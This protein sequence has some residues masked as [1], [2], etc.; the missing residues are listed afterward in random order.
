M[1]HGLARKGKQ[2]KAVMQLIEANQIPHEYLNLTANALNCKAKLGK[3]LGD[4][5]GIIFF[6]VKDNN[7]R[8]NRWLDKKFDNYRNHT[9]EHHYELDEKY[10]KVRMC[11]VM[12]LPPR[13]K[14]NSKLGGC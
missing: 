11:F 10:N 5:G 4:Q 2:T 8:L 14:K 7:S 1:I 9:I 3:L 13:A 6:A 12:T